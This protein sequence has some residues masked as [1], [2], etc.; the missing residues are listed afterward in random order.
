[1]NPRDDHELR[2]WAMRAG[3]TGAKVR[4]AVRAGRRRRGQADQRPVDRVVKLLSAGMTAIW[5][6]DAALF[7]AIHA[8]GRGLPT[9]TPAARQGN[10]LM[11]VALNGAA[12]ISNTG[13]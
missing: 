11:T 1:M 5:G 6:H 9:V 2:L 7:W 12:N 8:A 3:L 10:C 4:Q 13:A